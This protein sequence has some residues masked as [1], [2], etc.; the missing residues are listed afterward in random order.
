MYFITLNYANNKHLLAT[1]KE[2][3]YLYA[4]TLWLQRLRKVLKPDCSLAVAIMK[5]YIF[6]LQGISIENI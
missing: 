2:S 6:A 4:E 5:K 3:H 1:C